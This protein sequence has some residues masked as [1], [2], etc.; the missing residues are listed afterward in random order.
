MRKL[1]VVATLVIGAEM[2]YD[3]IAF[4]RDNVFRDR[5]LAD[6]NSQFEEFA[7]NP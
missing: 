6:I 1:V 2:R 5:G 4:Q 3:Q 7:V